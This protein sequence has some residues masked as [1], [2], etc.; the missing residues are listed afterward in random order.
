[1]SKKYTIEFT[2]EELQKFQSYLMWSTTSYTDRTM[3]DLVNKMVRDIQLEKD[4]QRQQE[5]FKDF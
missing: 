2:F 5:L 1:M 4:N 3:L